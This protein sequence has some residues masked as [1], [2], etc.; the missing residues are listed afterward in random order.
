V[1]DYIDDV[2]MSGYFEVVLIIIRVGRNLLKAGS[3]ECVS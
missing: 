1:N 3:C 2:L